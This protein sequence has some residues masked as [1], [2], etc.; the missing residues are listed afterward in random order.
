MPVG[1]Y[2]KEKPEFTNH[3]IDLQKG[4][5]FYLFSDGYQDQFGGKDGTKF[6]IKRLKEVLGEIQDKSMNEQKEFLEKTFDDWKGNYD[7]LDDVI[8]IGVRINQ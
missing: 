7:Q 6:K 4:D 1:I 5:T 8:L 2:I 3:V